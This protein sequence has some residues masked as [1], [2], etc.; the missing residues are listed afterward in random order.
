MY[1]EI[2]GLELDMEDKCLVKQILECFLRLT[3]DRWQARAWNKFE[4]F[5]QFCR[6]NNTINLSQQLDGN[7]FGELEKCCGIGI[8]L[9]EIWHKW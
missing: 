6:D 9:L 5:D 2:T 7:R 8:Y 4:E 1:P 3:A